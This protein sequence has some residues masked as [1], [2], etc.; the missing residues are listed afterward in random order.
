MFTAWTEHK[1]PILWVFGDPGSGKSHLSTWTI[2]YLQRLYGDNTAQSGGV[3][4]AY[5]YIRESEQQLRDPNTILKTLAWQIAEC[6]SRFTK[7]AAEVCSS[8][9]KIISAEQTWINLFVAFYR[10]IANVDQSSMLVIDGLDEAPEAARSTLLG[11]FKGLLS[12]N[13]NG[14]RPRIQVAIIGRITLKGDMDFVRE[15]K[16]IEVSRE[17]NQEDLGRYIDQRL[18]SINIM[19][20]L[21][22]LDHRDAKKRLGKQTG[23][24]APKVKD[25]LK[26][27]IS[28]YA[29]GLFL[30]AKLLLDQIHDKDYGEVEKIL[31]RRP[32]NLE[33][34]VKHVYE[35]LAAEEEDWRA[36][37]KLL[38][39][40]AYAQRPLLF[41]EIELVLS[42]PSAEP[43]LLLWDKFQGKLASIFALKIPEHNV[44]DKYEAL[45]QSRDLTK[46][47]PIDQDEMETQAKENLSQDNPQAEDNNTEDRLDDQKDADLSSEE[48][49]DRSDHHSDTSEFKLLDDLKVDRGLDM[50][51]TGR[52]SSVAG[53]YL[54]AYADW[55]SKTLITF[56]HLQ[57][58]EFLVLKDQ[59]RPI[60]LD[61]NVARSHLE[62][63]LTCF[64]LLQL[65]LDAQRSSE[66]LID[67]PR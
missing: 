64:E 41:G 27:K 44:S 52:F 2:K 21:V 47:M 48:S 5:F 3:S 17:K 8:K 65:G 49:S 30:W 35:R 38:T 55:Q 31:K 28:E 15:E 46:Q 22:E 33:G 45:R 58:R 18:S 29:D 53:E 12:E 54:H 42:L 39:W 61:I 24:R 63:T 37:K 25:K 36:I 62:I 57:F 9:K 16:F 4:V 59:R 10:S 7:H 43:N 51:S 6:D 14:T 26:R 34:M 32:S 23:L 40:A 67:Y 11:F 20:R 1:I 60:D 66:Y 50:L 13:A 56:S 19:K